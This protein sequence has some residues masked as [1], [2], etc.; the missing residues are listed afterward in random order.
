MKYLRKF[1]ESFQNVKELELN[2][3]MMYQTSAIIN[4]IPR[5]EYSKN[6]NK[7]GVLIKST[8]EEEVFLK[9]FGE[10]RGD[11]DDVFIYFVTSVMNEDLMLKIFS[12]V[13]TQE[14]A[15]LEE[16]FVSPLEINGRIVL[17]LHS[18]ERGSSIRI[19]V[20]DNYTIKFEEVL[21]IVDTL[22]QIYNQKLK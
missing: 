1:N 13:R 22:C 16:E 12:N 10:W 7:L 5:H 15:D 19:E 11:Y 4:L 9:L 8:L 3:D 6:M 14:G 2:D 20:D 18:P 17:I 21:G